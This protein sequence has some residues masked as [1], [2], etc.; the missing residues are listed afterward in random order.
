MSD[1][2]DALYWRR[3]RKFLPVL[4]IVPGLRMVAVCN[5]LA[6]GKVRADSDIDLFIVARKGRLFTVR[7][8]VTLILSL[9]RVRR[10]GEKI[11]GRF[12]LSFFV[13]DSALDLS[14]VA[15]Y[16]DIYLA[17]WLRSMLPVIDDGVSAELV[18]ANRWIDTYFES[19]NWGISR[20]YLFAPRRLFAAIKFV[21][22]WTFDLIFG[23]ILE[24][25]LSTWQMRRARKKSSQ[26]GSEASL[27]ITRN[28]L[29]F[30]NVDRR[31]HYREK[32]ESSYAG[33]KLTRKKFLSL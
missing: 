4:Q 9:M 3:V 12:C 13:D 28:M 7:T 10:H 27:V 33:E 29:K 23:A 5:N 18:N 16:N 11:A 24:F 1:S 15:I 26:C 21:Y 14:K 6:F 22:R 25:V 32:W 8:F 19:P 17:Y 20:K 31:A 30:H 2:I